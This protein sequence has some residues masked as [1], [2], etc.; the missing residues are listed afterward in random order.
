MFKKVIPVIGLIALGI[1]ACSKSDSSN[2]TSVVPGNGSGNGP[3]NNPGSGNANTPYGSI[4]GDTI[5]LTIKGDS[6]Y[7][8]Y[9]TGMKLSYQIK[10]IWYPYKTTDFTIQRVRDI[11]TDTA[12]YVILQ[13]NSS[14]KDSLL[15][16]QF[17]QGTYLQFENATSVPKNTSRIWKWIDDKVDSWTEEKVE[18]GVTTTISRKITGRKETVRVGNKVFQNVLRVEVERRS[19]SDASQGISTWVSYYAPGIGLIQEAALNDT[20]KLTAISLPK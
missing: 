16:Y 12:R 5:A 15:Y 4:A 18:N 7:F 3:G 11:V 13:D 17:K 1:V 19:R 10:E 9:T 14:G 6:S 2:P 8:P 20:I